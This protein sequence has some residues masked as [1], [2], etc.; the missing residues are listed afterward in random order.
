MIGSLGNTEVVGSFLSQ[1]TRK[2]VELLWCS[3]MPLSGKGIKDILFQMSPWATCCLRATSWVGQ[4][5]VLKGKYYTNF[6]TS[7]KYNY[8]TIY[9]NK[10]QQKCGMGFKHV[11]K[12]CQL[13]GYLQSFGFLCQISPTGQKTFFAAYKTGCHELNTLKCANGG[14]IRCFNSL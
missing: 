13:K 14:R 9:Q 12:S 11:T 4:P 1:F 2:Q 7:Y 5:C 6:N 10:N 3:I 8:S